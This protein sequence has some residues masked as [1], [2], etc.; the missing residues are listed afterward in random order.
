MNGARRRV[1]IDL[2]KLN[3]DGKTKKSPIS[4]PILIQA[5]AAAEKGDAVPVDQI[6]LNDGRP[7]MPLILPNGKFRIRALDQSGR[8]LGEYQKN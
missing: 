1:K 2:K 8:I 3:L 4:Q 5:F 6:L 7:P